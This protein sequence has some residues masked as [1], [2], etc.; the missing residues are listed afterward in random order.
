[1]DAERWTRVEQLCQAALERDEHEQAAFLASAC[2]SDQ[3]LR[4]EV[5]SL[6]VHRDKAVTFMEGGAMD[7]AAQVLAADGEQ[8]PLDSSRWAGR[9]VGSYRIVAKV[10]SGGMGDVYRATRADGT[11]DKQVAIKLIQGAR[12]TDYFLSR[13]Q[14]ERQILATLDHPNIARLLDGGTTEEGLPYLVMEYIQ[15][16]PIDD[17][18]AQKNLDTRER[19]ELFRTVCSAVQFAHQNLVVHRDLKPSNILVTSDGVPKLLDFGI[20]KILNPADRDD[21]AQQTMTLMRMLTPDYA[22]PEQVRN[23]PISTASDVYSLGVILYVLLT[24]QSPY[25][26]PTGSPEEMLKAICDVDP[27][28]PSTASTR[29][30]QRDAALTVPASSSSEVSRSEKEKRRKL[31]KILEG[32]LDNIVL[33]ALRKEPGRRYA[34]VDQ[35][36]EDIR[37]YLAGLPILA[38][39]DTPGYRSRKFIGRHKWGVAAVALLIVSLSA[40]LITTLWQARIARAERARAERRFNDVRTLANSLIFDIH[41]SIQE[42]PGATAARKAIVDRAL[43]YLDSLSKESSGDI[44]LRR[45]L[46]TAYQRVGALQGSSNGAN[47]GDTKGALESFEKAQALW[48]D[49]AGANPNN[50]PDQVNVAKGHR[51][52]S[53]MYQ[54]AARPGARGQLEQAMALSANLLKKAPS[55]NLLLRERS[56]EFQWMSANYEDDGNYNASVEALRN[57]ISINE[58][59]LKTSTN[60]EFLRHGIAMNNIKIANALSTL[61]SREKALELNRSG[62]DYYE[63]AAKNP[64]L[65]TAKREMAV[66]LF[67][68]GAILLSNGDAA[69]ALESFRQSQAISRDMQKA[70]PSN[71]VLL[72]DL[73]GG[74]AG[75]G[76]ALGAHGQL[77]DA[78]ATLEQ[79]L[80]I[81]AELR[82]RDPLYQDLPALMGQFSI[83][84]GD[85][86]SRLGDIAEAQKSYQKAQPNFDEVAKA[87]PTPKSRCDRGTVSAKLGHVLVLLKDFDGARD[88]FQKALEF[89]ESLASQSPAD[90]L[91]LYVLADAYS[92]LG[93]L[94]A[95]RAA[96]IKE[97]SEKIAHWKSAVSWYEKS[98]EVS[99]NIQNQSEYSPES[100]TTVRPDDVR[101]RLDDSLRHLARSGAD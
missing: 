57:A 45:D 36:S 53:M 8:T 70:D 11:F 46:A 28:K 24:G 23:E 14:N 99:R 38:H 13:F 61:G 89:T 87:A 77:R 40:G 75:V 49:V 7:A 93:D 78:L 37:R 66:T 68:R 29:A 63:V 72:A 74:T 84:K 48:E 97:A 59:L 47:V 100:F 21:S 90:P 25:R 69:R 50:L 51:I 82:A 95:S 17:F 44:S 71:T 79:S 88:E 62:L 12:S 22:S 83:W 3:E 15:G 27:E 94:E 81:F 34:S 85:V 30:S 91:A 43:Q 39:N 32:D 76:V 16:L 58:E 52:L 6:L 1:M 92:G 20:A 41:D 4:R 101:D 60:T 31:Q 54:N 56:V 33:K 65:A 19:L 96:Q 67:Y 26:V 80:A 98:L 10:A 2:G 18:C 9:L 55:D 64:N 73:G 35:F 42:L 86:L 5:E